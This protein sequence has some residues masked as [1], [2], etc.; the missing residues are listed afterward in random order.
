MSKMP[1][2]KPVKSCYEHI[3]GKPG[4]LLL[5]QFAEKG[6]VAKVDPADKNFYITDKG[7]KEFTRLGIDLSQIKP[8]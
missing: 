5:E 7:E 4:M 3:G 8:E 2:R 1:T 6:W